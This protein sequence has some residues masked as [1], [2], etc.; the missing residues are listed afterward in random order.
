MPQDVLIVA[1]RFAR[2]RVMERFAPA[3]DRELLS[4]LH[5]GLLAQIEVH[6]VAFDGHDHPLQRLERLHELVGHE[7]E[8]RADA[9]GQPGLGGGSHQDGHHGPAKERA[10][11]AVLTG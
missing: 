1:E 4:D 5:A 10:G 11:H 8:G 6:R 3:E 2:D 7:G 9:I